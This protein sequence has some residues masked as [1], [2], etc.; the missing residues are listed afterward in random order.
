MKTTKVKSFTLK[1]LLDLANEAYDD[2]FL[3]NYYTKKGALKRGSGDTLAKFIVIE[4]SETFTPSSHP[5]KQLYEAM[6]VLES[7][8][9]Q[10][11]DIE[12]KLEGEFDA[13]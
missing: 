6:K 10:L 8:R 3:A 9:Y 5:K 2:G 1:E 11:K 7:A 13:L 4:L 12:E